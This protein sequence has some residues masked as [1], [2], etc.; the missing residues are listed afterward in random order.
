MAQK[1][2][3][4]VRQ[5]TSNPR[6]THPLLKGGGRYIPGTNHWTFLSAT[7]PFCDWTSALRRFWLKRRISA[8]G[9]RATQA[10]ASSCSSLSRE[11][12]SSNDVNSD[13]MTPV[14]TQMKLYGRRPAKAEQNP[15]WTDM[16][17]FVFAEFAVKKMLDEYL[18]N[19]QK[20]R[21]VNMSHNLELKS[22]L[23]GQQRNM[24][25]VVL[26][27]WVRVW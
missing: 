25:C 20:A 12:R 23:K 27:Q 26:I 10:M 21:N 6:K 14:C 2:Q 1:H 8:P 4:L 3:H 22:D 16:L 18:L 7:D 15:G 11:N 5:N 13:S 17:S 24:L 9:S 19:L